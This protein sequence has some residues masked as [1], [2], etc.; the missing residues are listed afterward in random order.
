M[1]PGLVAT[2]TAAIIAGELVKFIF[3]GALEE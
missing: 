3:K 1:I 2:T